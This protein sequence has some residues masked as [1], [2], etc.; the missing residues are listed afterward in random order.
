M[1]SALKQHRVKTK[2]P[3]NPQQRDHEMHMPHERDESD[4]SE[5]G[6]LPTERVERVDIKRAYEDL[7]EGQVNTDLRGVQGVDQV[8]NP[9]DGNTAADK[10]RRQTPR[11]R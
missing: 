5:T 7:S 9:P 6:A 2:K 11:A 10:A 1:V 8:S 4:E 3:D